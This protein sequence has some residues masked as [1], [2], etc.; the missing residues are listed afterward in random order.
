VCQVSA[1]YEYTFASYGRKYKVCEKM[2]K[3]KNE[4]IIACSYHG[5]GWHNLLQIWYIDL[6]SWGASLQQVWLNSAEWSQTYIGKKST[7]FVFLSIYSWCNVTAS[8]ATR[9]T[10]MSL[11]MQDTHAH[12]HTW[13]YTHFIIA[14]SHSRTMSMYNHSQTHDILHAQTKKKFQAACMW[15]QST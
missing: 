10:I 9:H 13:Y 11:D 1:W 14:L 2:K 5:I 4:E 8:L 15:S 6:P 3:K 12:T 7:F